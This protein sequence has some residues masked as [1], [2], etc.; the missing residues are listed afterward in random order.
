MIPA[1]FDYARPAS[2]DEAL[3][4]LADGRPGTKVL[5]GGH[6]LL[7]LLKLRLAS[8]ERLVDI[9]RLA[10]LRGVRG[11]PGGGFAVGALTTYAELLDSPVTQL[12]LMAD[13][14]PGIGDVQV[15]NRGTI[16]GSVAHSDP[17]S[18]MPA[19]LLAL[20]ATLVARSRRGE[21]TI[22]MRDFIVDSFATRLEPDEILTEIRLPAPS[23]DYGSAYASLEQPAS[24]YSIVGVAV[25]VGRRGGP[26]SALDDVR[27]GITGVGPAPYRAAAAEAA[28]AGAEDPAS[29][30]TAAAALAADGIVVNGDIH[31]D[32]EYRT[33][34]TEVFTRRALETA[35]RRVG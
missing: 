15:R 28:L 33:A 17:A 13:V 18:D 20:E 12:A 25:V 29:A 14:L 24:G 34:M 16:G 32:R 6:S 9:G 7:P 1:A 21:R 4:L 5:A 3:A 8:A 19:V 11:L 2:L 26:G 35:I 23:G 10:E 31:A 22:A 27:I 30:V